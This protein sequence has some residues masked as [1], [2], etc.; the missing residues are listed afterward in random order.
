MSITLF[1]GPMCSGKTSSLFEQFEMYKDYYPVYVYVP[2]LDTRSKLSLK[3]HNGQIVAAQCLDNVR[4]LP[5]DSVV[6]LD[7]VQFNTGHVIDLL[8]TVPPTTTV[9]MSGLSGDFKQ[10]GWPGMENVMALCDDVFFLKAKCTICNEDA[11]FTVRK[12]TNSTDLVVCGGTDLYEPRC[13]K[14][15]STTI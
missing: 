12:G 3:T 9:Y 13:R 4:C 2:S 10:R 7:E 11:P 15:V 5:A 6:L 8:K 14:C 1:V